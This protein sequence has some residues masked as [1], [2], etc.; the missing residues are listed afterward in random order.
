MSIF[1]GV[2][3]SASL[4]SGADVMFQN[5]FAAPGGISKSLI[6]LL[7][8]IGTVKAISFVISFFFKEGN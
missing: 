3:L 7:T 5:W 4:L 8:L 2:L 1:L 6:M